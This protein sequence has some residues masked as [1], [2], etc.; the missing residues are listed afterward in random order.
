MNGEAQPKAQT[1]FS[2]H[3][4]AYWA[5]REAYEKHHSETQAHLADSD[6]LQSDYDSAYTPLVSAMHATADAAVR[7]S[8]NTAA[9]VFQKIEIFLNESLHEQDRSEVRELIEC[10]GRDAAK[11]GGAA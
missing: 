2:I 10:L 8:A 5:A 7:T 6:P 4:A 1:P 9:E 11:I 3:A